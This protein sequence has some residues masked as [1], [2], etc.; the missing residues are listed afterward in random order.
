MGVIGVALVS[1]YEARTYIFG[2][3]EFFS[4][5]SFDIHGC[6]SQL[7]IYIGRKLATMEYRIV[8]TLLILNL[9]FLELPPE[10]K[11]L[12]ASEQVFRAPDMPYVRLREI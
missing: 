8:I 3:E 2:F 4:L 9:E 12:K 11:T 7:S 1:P 5:L 10:Y 6:Q